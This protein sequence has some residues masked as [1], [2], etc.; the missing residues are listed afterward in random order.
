MRQAAALNAALIW[1]ELEPLL[2]LKEDVGTEGRLRLGG[3]ARPGRQ[4]RWV[5]EQRLL[6]QR[7]VGGVQGRGSVR[8]NCSGRG[9]DYS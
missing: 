1:R 5:S 3:H 9:P 2:E 8:M 7:L 6:E 4:I